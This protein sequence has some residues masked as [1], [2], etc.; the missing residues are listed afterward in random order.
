MELWIVVTFA[1]AA[2][3]TLRFMLQKKVRASGL[4]TGGA[5]FSRFVFAAPLSV[6]IAWAVGRALDPSLA[7]PPPGFWAYALGGGLGQIAGTFCTV[8][9]FSLR[10]FAVGIAFTKTET[11]Q[12]AVLSA[13]V[14]GEAVTGAGLLAILIGLVGVILLSLPAGGLATRLVFNRAMALGLFGGAAFGLSA[15]GYRGAA[16]SLGDAHFFFRAAA[17]LAA[18]TVMQ[19]AIMGFWLRAVEP[20]Q[21]TRVL[22]G[23]RITGLVGLTGM[24]GSLCWFTAF[25]LQNAAYVRALGQVELIFGLLVTA[26]IFRERITRR[27]LSGTAFLGISIVMIVMLN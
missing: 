10:N 21:I 14:L 6:L 16:L 25:T 27:E 8:A 26:L 17:T 9:L 22:K 4:S 2:V 13:L 5:T 12:V 15:I 1:A 19:T 23:W 11:V 18:V 20:G 7:P 3:Q 24:L